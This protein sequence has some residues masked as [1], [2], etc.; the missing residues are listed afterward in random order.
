MP[1]YKLS[2]FDFDG[3][4]AEAIRIAFHSGKIEFDDHRLSFAQF[5][6]FRQSTPFNSIPVLEIDGNLITQTNPIL[7]YIGKLTHLYPINDLQALYCEEVMSAIEDISHHL[8]KTF[9]LK[10]DEL[11]QAREQFVKGW[12]STILKGLESLLI[13]SNDDY[14]CDG[15]LT[16]ADIKC[17]VQINSLTKGAL[18]HVPTDLVES[19]TPKLFAHF[20]RMKNEP[21]IQAYYTMRTEK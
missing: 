7:S 8:V 12:L 20:N 2:Y 1:N 4:R 17:F 9:G 6:E 10:D 21:I 15:K 16:V 13:R 3:G 5:A 11:K 18:D 19:L 14:F